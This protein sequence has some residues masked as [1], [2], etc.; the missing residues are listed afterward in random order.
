MRMPILICAIGSVPANWKMYKVPSIWTVTQWLPDF[1]LRL[2]Q[3]QRLAGEQNSLGQSVI[4][5]GGLFFP[6][7]FLTATRQDS[8]HRSRVSLEELQLEVHVNDTSESGFAVDG[9]YLE[10]AVY[11]N[12][13]VHPS[14][15]DPVK[16]DTCTLKW[17]AADAVRHLHNPITIPVYLNS[18]VREVVLF[19]V[20]LDAE[21]ALSQADAT[22]RSI[23][24]TASI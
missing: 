21:D 11:E 2:Q 24:L 18:K 19:S 4:W 7:S 13:K 17:T 1:S 8:A 9:L 10:G 22:Q 6:G 16:L 3:M 12:G 15:T 5:F 20:Q 23:C 14:N